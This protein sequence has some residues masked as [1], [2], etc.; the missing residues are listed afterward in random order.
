MKK[1]LTSLIIGFT[2]TATS[3]FT[4]AENLAAVYQQAL[5]SDPTVL[6]AQ[7]Q[8]MASQE[9]IELARA[10]LLPQI[11]ASASY[12]RRESESTNYNGSFADLAPVGSIMTSTSKE[13]S[14]GASLSLEL[15]HHDSWLKMDNAKKAAHLSDLSYQIAKQELIVRVT[16]AYFSVLSAQDDLEFSKAEKA[17]IE[18]QLEQTKQR[19][20][21]GLTAITDVH[22]AQAKFDNAITDEIRA[23]N[24]VYSREEELRAITN[25][26]PGNLSV[27]DTQSFSTSKPMPSSAN[28]WQS[29]AEDKSLDLIAQKV[30]AD[31]SKENINIAQAGHYPTLDLNGRYGSAK[32]KSSLSAANGSLDFPDTPYYDN[33]SIGITF[34]VPIY[35]GGATSSLVRQAQQNY[36][37]ASQDLELA[38]RSVVRNVRTA[39]NAVNAA[40]SAIK[41]LEQSVLS[42]ESALKA[43][44]AGF[45]VGTRTIVD[46]LNSTQNLY[47]AKRN[48]SST[49][50]SYIE[51]VLALKRAGGTISEQDIADISRGLSAKK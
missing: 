51:S 32:D 26:Y 40:I 43:T 31:I 13:T 19:F 10:A 21:V 12:T 20:A 42:A 44:E 27:L 18:R 7:A 2:L 23:Q 1:S 48:L 46:V 39:Y 16:R 37:A 33:Q 22:E 35:S 30:N 45:E 9:N 6:K 38:H 49:R 14:Y 50:Y 29:L 36:V 25:V 28:E 17:A 4:F 8:A 24:N 5:A 11:G 15:Y 47:N 41:S 34:T 3:S